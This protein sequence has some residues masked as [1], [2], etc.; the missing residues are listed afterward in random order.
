MGYVS[1]REGIAPDI[2]VYKGE[3]TPVTNFFWTFIGVI[4]PSITGD[5]AHL[6]LRGSPQVISSWA[7]LIVMSK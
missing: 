4:T 7:V 3:I 6:V 2:F 1:F 5:G